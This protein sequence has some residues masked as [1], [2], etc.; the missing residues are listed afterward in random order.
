MTVVTIIKTEDTINTRR[1]HPA[2]PDR[3]SETGT[4][5]VREGVGK[6]D[7][8]KSDSSKTPK[9]RD[10]SK[11]RRNSLKIAITVRKTGNTVR[12]QNQSMNRNKTNRRDSEKR[13]IEI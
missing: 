4:V 12:S 11:L 8:G 10:N 13:K 2:T 3:K 7:E 5:V 1:K 6:S 9:K